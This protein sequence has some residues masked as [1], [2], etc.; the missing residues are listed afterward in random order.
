MRGAAHCD[1]KVLSKTVSATYGNKRSI[2]TSRYTGW[3]IRGAGVPV[4][5]GYKIFT[6]PYSADSSEVHTTSYKMDTW[7]SFPGVKRQGREADHSTP[8]IAEVMKMWIHS[9]IRLH[10]VMLN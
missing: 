9:P 6:S 7:G 10:G 4:P 5:V 1:G 3:T 8:T 2:I